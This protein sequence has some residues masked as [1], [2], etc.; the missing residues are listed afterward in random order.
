MPHSGL[1]AEIGDAVEEATAYTMNNFGG[2]RTVDEKDK[3]QEQRERSVSKRSRTVCHG[4]S[5]GALEKQY[6]ALS[7]IQQLPFSRRQRKSWSS[8]LW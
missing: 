3:E 4:Q 1:R 6:K 8:T 2:E 7:W 5:R